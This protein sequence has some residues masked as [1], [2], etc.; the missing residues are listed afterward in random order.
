MSM[1]RKIAIVDPVG[2]KAGLDH[3]DRE[4]AASLRKQGFSVD[5]YS[6]FS[7]TDEELRVFP[8][9]F[10]RNPL[11]IPTLYLI[12]R[13]LIAR[14]VATNIRTI[15]CHL[16]H[17]NKID[18]WFL[19]RCKQFNLYTIVI[20]HDVESHLSKSNNDQ[21]LAECL[22]L[23]SQIIVHSQYSRTELVAKFTSKFEVNT[24]TIPHG[25][26]LSLPTRTSRIEAYKKLKLNPNKKYVLF[27]GM[28][29]P[30]KGLDVLIKAMK[31]QNADLIIAG[32]LRKQSFDE[33]EQLISENNL[34]DR[35][36]RFVRYISNDERDLFFKVAD[37]IV[38]PY[39]KVYQS[40]VLLMAMSYG[41]PVVVSDLLPFREI[42][43]HKI[44]GLVFKKGDVG[45]LS[46]KIMEALLK[47]EETE[48]RAKRAHDDM[49]TNHS[50]DDFADKVKGMIG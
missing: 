22:D 38:L 10:W 39:E 43:Q 9:R 44:N 37:L 40:G 46:E 25:H 20:L 41:L 1:E 29:K 47:T 13:R 50:W 12:Y 8:F 7:D 33:F 30:T 11:L 19:K 42:V 49:K 36:H 23:A 31:D 4:L 32:R 16:F 34:R 6:N 3:Y 2:C 15:I 35:V 18:L 24:V 27:F 17:A 26:F 45:D 5:I 48:S 28:I 21:S 14:C